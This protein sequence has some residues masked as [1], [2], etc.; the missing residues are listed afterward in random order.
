MKEYTKRM[1]LL[2]IICLFTLIALVVAIKLNEN[3]ME[4]ELSISV[5]DK[6][7]TEIKYDEIANYTVENNDAII[8]V[9]NSSEDSSR[10]FEKMFIPVIRK[11][12]LES[13]IVYINI[14]NANISD[15]FYQVAPEMI[16]YKNG[17]ISDIIGCDSIETKKD[18]INILKERSVI[19]D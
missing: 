14:N 4:N 7:L 16:F 11:Y 9:S 13:N 12:N 18:L 10:K 15:P 8:Y 1:I 6:K 19:G 5:I 17:I 2:I 3:R